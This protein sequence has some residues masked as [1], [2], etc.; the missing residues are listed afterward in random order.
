M[1]GGQPC[2][3]SQLLVQRMWLSPLLYRH[4]I[5][6]E[7]AIFKILNFGFSKFAVD[8]TTLLTSLRLDGGSE[9][10]LSSGL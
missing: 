2:C 4:Y 10:P 3:Q 5:N 1:S 8:L 6:D 7:Q 9:F